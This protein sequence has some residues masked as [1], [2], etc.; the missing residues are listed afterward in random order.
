MEQT[1]QWIYNDDIPK[2]FIAE[3]N[4]DERQY[5]LAILNL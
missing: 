1:C 4:E 2:Y 3:M 5:V